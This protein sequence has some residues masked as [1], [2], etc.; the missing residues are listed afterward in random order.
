MFLKISYK[1]FTSFLMNIPI[2][3]LVFD[4][5]DFRDINQKCKHLLLCDEKN[6]KNNF[7]GKN[8]DFLKQK[9]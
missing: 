1:S 2:Q 4:Y 7:N 8:V 6:N 5:S 9:R 3:Y